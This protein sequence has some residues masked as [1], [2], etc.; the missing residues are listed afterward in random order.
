MFE[1][2]TGFRRSWIVAT[3]LLLMAGA[4]GCARSFAGEAAVGDGLLALDVFTRATEGYH[5]YRIPSLV[6]A[7]NGTLMALVE[8]RRDRAHDPGGGHIDL[9]CKRSQ[10]GGRTWSAPADLTRSGRD[11]ARWATAV[12]GPG[13][14]IQTRQGRLVIPVN[15]REPLPESEVL[16]RAAFALYSDDGGQTWS[17]PRSG[18]SVT[19]VCTSILRYPTSGQAGQGSLLLWTGPRGPGRQDLVLRLSQDQGHL[20]AAERAP[21]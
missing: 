19:P 12:F 3:G 11:V 2:S 8:G 14:G 21:D 9:V 13:N 5:T 7:N 10:D 17:E 4:A 18:Q 6:K 1:T 15:A 20:F 16:R